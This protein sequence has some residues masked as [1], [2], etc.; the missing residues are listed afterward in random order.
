MTV[1]TWESAELCCEQATRGGT[2][3]QVKTDPCYPTDGPC[4][5]GK[6]KLEYRDS[7]AGVGEGDNSLVKNSSNNFVCTDLASKAIGWK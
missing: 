4:P 5:E 3:S 6:G 2:R 7:D 1:D